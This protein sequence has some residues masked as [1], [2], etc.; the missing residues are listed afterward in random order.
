MKKNENE[1]GT[2]V[3]VGTFDGVHPGHREVLRTLKSYALA[4]GLR[5]LAVT[6]DRHPLE[7]VAPARAPRLLQTRADRDRLLREEGVEVE[8][9]AFIPE[10][11]SLTAEDWMRQLRDR[12]GA[13]AIVTGYDNTFGSDGRHMTA[14]DYQAAGQRLGLDIVTAPE[15]PG[16]CSSSIRKAVGD[17]NVRET[18]RL[19]GR[20][21]EVEG[22]VEEGRQLGRSLGF[23]TANLHPDSR[24]QLPAPGVYAGRLDGQPAVINIGNNPTVGE[25]NPLTVEVHVLDFAG[26]LYGKRVRASFTERLRGEMKFDSLD[27]LKYQIAEDIKEA[28]GIITK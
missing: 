17:G 7:I 4:H 10:V 15:L 22:V 16:V 6:F 5:P 1:N 27:S 14:A 28:R 23:P 11:C 24:I 26:D 19:L 3:T 2:V 18:S 20:E 13:R 21:Y 12:Y 25:G 9:V 8:E